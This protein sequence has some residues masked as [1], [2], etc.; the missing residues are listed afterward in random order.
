ME[1]LSDPHMSVALAPV[2]LAPVGLALA[3]ATGRRAVEVGSRSAADASVAVLRLQF[4]VLMSLPGHRQVVMS[5]TV[6]IGL[7]LH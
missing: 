2:C 7:L 5:L 3:P 4:R 6:V 1:H